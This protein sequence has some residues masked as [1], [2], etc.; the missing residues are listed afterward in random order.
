MFEIKSKTIQD[1]TGIKIFVPVY[2]DPVKLKS[3]NFGKYFN[4]T[5]S[6][7]QFWILDAKLIIYQSRVNMR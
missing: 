1:Q 5:N 3:H 4:G 2:N 6:G 7:K